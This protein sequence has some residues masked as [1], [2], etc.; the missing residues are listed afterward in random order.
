MPFP[1]SFTN[2]YRLNISN[3]FSGCSD[4]RKGCIREQIPPFFYTRVST[5]LPALNLHSPKGRTGIIPF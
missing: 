1:S 4:Y 3:L 2:K 5:C